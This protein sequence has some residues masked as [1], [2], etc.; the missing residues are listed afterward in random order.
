[1]VRIPP[2]L[3]NVLVKTQVG[4]YRVVLSGLMV[5]NGFVV[6]LSNSKVRMLLKETCAPKLTE[7]VED[8]RWLLSSE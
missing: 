2:V 5:Q 3:A 4:E 7:Q 6:T 8:D 1:M